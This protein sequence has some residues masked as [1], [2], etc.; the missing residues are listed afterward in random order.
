MTP[1]IRVASEDDWPAIWP[2]VREVVVAAERRSPHGPEMTEDEG[3]ALWMVASP[4]RTT[5]PLDGA[6]V[7]GDGERVREAVPAPGAHVGA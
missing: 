4:V 7:W 1:R 3:R 5:V 2:I 6:V